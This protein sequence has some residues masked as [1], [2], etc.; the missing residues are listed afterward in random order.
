[1]TVRAFRVII[2]LQSRLYF[3]PDVTSWPWRAVALIP[4]SCRR[5][6]RNETW[7]KGVFIGVVKGYCFTTWNQLF[8]L[9][10]D[11]WGCFY[12][13]DHFD[14]AFANDFF[15]VLPITNSLCKLCLAKAALLV[16]CNLAS[17]KIY[18]RTNY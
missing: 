6:L 1:M 2:S 14:R 12:F 13:I 5:W 16:K 11:V 10:A 4:A 3:T 17:Y 7:L 15:D 9:Q 8:P 18:H